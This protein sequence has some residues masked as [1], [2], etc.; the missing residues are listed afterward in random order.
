[1][2]TKTTFKR[3]ALATVAAMGFGMLSVAPSSAATTAPTIVVAT[4]TGSDGLN[5]TDTVT[6]ATTTFGAVTRT[7]VTVHTVPFTIDVVGTGF[8]ALTSQFS[9]V[10]DNTAADGTMTTTA[11][12]YTVAFAT[13]AATVVSATSATITGTIT[14]TADSKTKANVLAAAGTYSLGIN[15]KNAEL[16]SAITA[17]VVAFSTGSGV[18]FAD[19]TQLVA[20]VSNS[21]L[22]QVVGGQAN[23]LF[24]PTASS[25]AA[26]YAVTVTGATMRQASAGAATSAVFYTDSGNAIDGT[27]AGTYTQ[28]ITIAGDVDSNDPLTDVD[29]ITISFS[30][31]TAGVSTVSFTPISAAGVPGTATTAL[32]TWVASADSYG[33]ST[34]TK[35]LGTSNFSGSTYYAAATASANA[36]ATFSVVQNDT[37]GVALAAASLSKAVVITLTGTGSLASATAGGTTSVIAA[38]AATWANDG[39][40]R[41]SV[42]GNGIAGTG[43]LSVAVNGVTIWT[44]TIIFY[45]TPTSV[46]AEASYTIAR[47]GGYEVGDLDHTAGVPS[48]DNV[49]AIAVSLKDALGN[50]VP[51]AAVFVS[52][53]PA[54]IVSTP[55]DSFMD[56]GTGQY[57]AGFGVRHVTFSSTAA[58]VSGQSSDITFTH[59]LA[60]GVV[61]TSNVIKATVGGTRTGGSVAM[62]LDKATYEPGERMIL[63]FTAKDSAGNPVHD[64]AVTGTPASNKNA[65]GLLTSGDEYVGGKHVYGD[66]ATEFLYAPT[67]PGAFTLT[68]ASGTAT[69]AVVTV[70]AT[71][72]DD[73]A[74]TAAAAAGDAAAEATDA[75]NAATDAANAAAEAADAATAAAQDA[76]DAVAALSTSVTAMVD[77]LKKQITSLTNLVI[78][79]QKKVKA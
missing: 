45:G 71:V 53:N 20:K 63:T 34:V 27:N 36:V 24:R 18:Q 11:T 74:T 73:A 70:T 15:V 49:P 44:K 37:A 69:G 39:T 75:A 64:R 54:A 51:T 23:L 79:I 13:Q 40:G 6:A 41:F 62:T 4:P 2:S 30:S 3:I 31:A 25:S 50:V 14:V 48:A 57:S 33:N 78:K 38:P 26:R 59:T 55:T 77:A 47:A 17:P 67:T 76:A 5:T 21:N 32:I 8:A 28:G 42:F 16:D 9:V 7:N 65:S 29:T 66:G 1:M 72:G 56:T 58:S 61:L 22:S 43:T 46:V 35:V 60:S 52:S 68:L 10:A 19:P 12:A